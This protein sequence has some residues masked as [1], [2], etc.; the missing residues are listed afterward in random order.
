MPVSVFKAALTVEPHI[1]WPAKSSDV[2]DDMSPMVPKC[3]SS[4]DVTHISDV[5][6][7][8]HSV[9]ESP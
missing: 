5:V 3:P 9:G 2:D 6:E 8:S 7:F 1:H 4:P